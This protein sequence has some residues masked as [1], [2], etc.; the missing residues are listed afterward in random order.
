MGRNL[1]FV[2]A[3]VLLPVAVQAQTDEEVIARMLDAVGNQDCTFL[4]NNMSYSAREFQQFLRS[5]TQNNEELIDSAEDF[6]ELIATRS[7]TSEAPYTMLCDG[8]FMTTLEW[9][10]GLLE[11]LRG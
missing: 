9:F 8:E 6:I 1:L 2:A 5:K 11:D 10:S 4:R 3:A 7:S